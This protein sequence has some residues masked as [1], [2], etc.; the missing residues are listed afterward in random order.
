[1]YKYQVNYSKRF[2]DCLLVNQLYHDFLRFTDWD[3]AD[4]FKQ[5]CESGHVFKQFNGNGSYIVEDVIL[6]AID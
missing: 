6:T 1:M 5:L 3:S 4:E 2:K